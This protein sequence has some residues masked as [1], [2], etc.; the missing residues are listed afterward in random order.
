MSW[1]KNM[2]GFIGYI[3]G[4]IIILPVLLIVYNYFFINKNDVS[5]Y[6]AVYLK[7]STEVKVQVPAY[8]KSSL[9]N[10]NIYTTKSYTTSMQAKNMGRDGSKKSRIYYRLILDG[11]TNKYYQVTMFDLTNGFFG[12]IDNN[13]IYAKVNKDDFA[14]IKYG[15][16]GNPILAFSV[17][18]A[19]KPLTELRATKGNP[20]GSN[21]NINTSS[22]QYQYNAFMYLTYVMP[23]NEFKERFLKK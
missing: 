12:A 4:A 8:D 18:G 3:L 19:D 9:P 22:E 2:G 5:K 16:K 11:N 10:D 6:L 23:K 7:N 17:R 14:N 13:T 20:G 21:I 15:T 1:L